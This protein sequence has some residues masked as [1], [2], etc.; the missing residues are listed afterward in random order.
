MACMPAARV[1]IAKGV[2]DLAKATSWGA[3]FSEK[4]RPSYESSNPPSFIKR[5][6]ERAP[7]KLQKLALRSRLGGTQFANSVNREL[8]EGLDPLNTG[9]SHVELVQAKGNL[10]NI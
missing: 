8:E 2:M 7:T 4:K 10:Y 3:R 6:S 9:N 5:R 1:Y